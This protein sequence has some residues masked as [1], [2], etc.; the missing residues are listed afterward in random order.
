[1]SVR[2]ASQSCDDTYWHTT[3]PRVCLAGYLAA[4][5]GVARH[6]MARQGSALVLHCHPRSSE[7]GRCGVS[8]PCAAATPDTVAPVPA[9]IFIHTCDSIYPSHCTAPQSLDAIA[10]PWSVHSASLVWRDIDYDHIISLSH[11]QYHDLN[12]RK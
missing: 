2:A 4:P 7:S 11:Y 10:R 1:M 8:E 3:Q 9:N 6:E 12:T 5:Q